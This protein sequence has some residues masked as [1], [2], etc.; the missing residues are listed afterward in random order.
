M[1]GN[2]GRWILAKKTLST[3]K[4]VLRSVNAALEKK[5]KNIVILNVRKVSSISDYFIICSGSSDRQV[6]AISA[7]IEESLKKENRLP[8]GIE[9][10]RIGKW[11]LLDYGD[12]VIHIFYEPIREL[13]DLDRLWS[14]VPRMEVGEDAAEITSLQ[15]GL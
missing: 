13:Y 11:V 10:D 5:A 2:S 1:I 12:V 7:A 8:M 6:Q 14:D 15:R 4:T 9:G 3:R